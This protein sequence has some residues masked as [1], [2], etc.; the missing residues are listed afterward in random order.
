MFRRQFLVFGDDLQPLPVQGGQQGSVVG[1]VLGR[2]KRM[3]H[4]QY[5]VNLFLR[6]HAGDI[7]L[8]IA[9]VHLILQG[10]HAD[11]EKF[12]QVGGG[13]AEEFETFHQGNIFVSCLGE[14][15]VIEIEP[16]ELAV[17]KFL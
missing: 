4:F 5:L 11:H 13:D 12:I 15:P 6:C 16:A 14:T 17:S 7:L 2:H 10:S 3:G 9:C 8:C 1:G